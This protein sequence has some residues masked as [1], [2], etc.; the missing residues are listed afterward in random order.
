MG[1]AMSVIVKLIIC[2]VVSV[3]EAV[4]AIYKIALL[5]GIRA[6]CNYLALLYNVAI[7]DI[8]RKL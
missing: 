2:N 5:N 3:H 7:Q 8:V 6:Q 1:V 4:L